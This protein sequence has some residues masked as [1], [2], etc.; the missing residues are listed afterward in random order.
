MNL[1]KSRIKNFIQYIR[2]I[3]FYIPYV[4]L[5]YII[6]GGVYN[7]FFADKN[8]AKERQEEIKRQFRGEIL[9]KDKYHVF[10]IYVLVNGKEE[11]IYN[12]SVNLYQNVAVGDTIFKIGKEDS[13]IIKKKNLKI[14]VEYHDPIRVQKE[15]PLFN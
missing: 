12:P 3:K 9:G 8:A 4:I 5:T 10:K 6:L 2:H 15:D 7:L 13:A 11:T 14:K 1:N